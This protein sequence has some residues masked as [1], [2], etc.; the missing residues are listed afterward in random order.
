ML[1]AAAT[2]A[3]RPDFWDAICDDELKSSEEF[4]TEEDMASRQEQLVLERIEA[5]CD[6]AE[7]ANDVLAKLRAL[8]SS[9][10]NLS[11]KISDKSKSMAHNLSMI[12][13]AP[14]FPKQR[15]S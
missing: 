14:G 5:F 2:D 9:T 12:V 15:P 4:D 6:S 3:E 8:G 10:E 11:C 7:Y 13:F 1:T